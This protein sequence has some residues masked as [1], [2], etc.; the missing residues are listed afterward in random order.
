MRFGVHLPQLG[1]SAVRQSLIEW[2]EEA[3]RLG[4]HSGWVSDH[5]AWP[6]DIASKYPY[7]EDGSFPGGF[8]MPWLDPLG[9]LTF[10]AARTER[11]LLGTTVLILGYRPPV[12]T[13]KW[14]ATLDV[15]SG[16]RAIL[17]VGV[18]WMK[19]EF[20]VL[21]MPFDNRGARAD[22]QLEVFDALFTQP[23]P[24]FDGRFYRFGEIGFSPKPVNGTIPVWVGGSSA[25]AF[26]RVARY[27]DV[28]HA[29]FQ[30]AG[31]VAEAWEAVGEACSELGRDRGELELSVRVFLDPGAMMKPEVSLQGSTE[32]MVESVG[33]WSEIGVDHL[34]LDV[35]APGGAAG[36]LDAL[37]AF[38]AGVS[39]MR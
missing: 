11:L 33:R 14:M 36:R 18:G 30:P 1:R 22:E 23:E 13:A 21:G 39:P 7:S 9:T 38:M 35:V 37:R 15:L 34:L 24:S 26:R 6:R 31:E 4:L 16:G 28:F 5:V 17:G 20:D 32:E 2:A 27:G 3:E 10:A 25:P 19:E 8:D 29:A 12:L